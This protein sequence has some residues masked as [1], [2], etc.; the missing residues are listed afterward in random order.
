L[1][2]ETNPDVFKALNYLLKFFSVIT[3]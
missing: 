1:K 2:D 3:T